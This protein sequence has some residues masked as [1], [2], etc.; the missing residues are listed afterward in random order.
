MIGKV[1]P[2][3]PA[4]QSIPARHR[5]FRILPVAHVTTLPNILMMSSLTAAAK[6]AGHCQ[7]FNSGKRTCSKWSF[8]GLLGQSGSEWQLSNSDVDSIENN[9]IPVCYLDA[10]DES[11]FG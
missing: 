8:Q 10:Q 6:S 2:P 5:Q 1:G 4:K 9:V 7:R 11:I 3:A